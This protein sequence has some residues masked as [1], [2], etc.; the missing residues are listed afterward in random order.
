MPRQRDPR[1]E[2]REAM[3]I[4]EENGLLIER[5]SRGFYQVW[6]PHRAKSRFLGKRGNPTTL[7]A[8]VCELTNF[9]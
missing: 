9:R 6:Q 4:A 2:L 8:L 1:L 7:R 5:D 3:V